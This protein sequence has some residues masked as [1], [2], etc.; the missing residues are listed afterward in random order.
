M[1][2]NMHRMIGKVYMSKNVCTDYQ[3]R[4]KIRSCHSYF[5]SYWINFKFLA[6]L[7]Q[8]VDANL[9]PYNLINRRKKLSEKLPQEISQVTFV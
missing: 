6:D 8:S 5:E 2:S 3:L 7:N 9:I 4:H 1:I